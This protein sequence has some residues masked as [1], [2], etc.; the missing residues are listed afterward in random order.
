MEKFLEDWGPKS[1]HADVSAARVRRTRSCDSGVIQI[2]VFS[3]QDEIPL[4]VDRDQRQIAYSPFAYCV[5]PSGRN[6]KFIDIF[7]R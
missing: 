2:V 1:P 5:D 6:T 3:P 4:Y 7:F